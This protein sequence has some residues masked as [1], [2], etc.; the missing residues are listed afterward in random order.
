MTSTT[1]LLDNPPSISA[2]QLHEILLTAHAS[3]NV[4]RLRFMDAL[5]ALHE[6]R[7]YMELGFPDIAAYADCTFH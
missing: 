1:L 2:A 3:G 4:A 6:S 5:R 7:L